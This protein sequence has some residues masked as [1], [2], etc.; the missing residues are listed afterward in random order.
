MRD[1]LKNFAKW[2]DAWSSKND[3]LDS[4]EEEL[5]AGECTVQ[6]LRVLWTNRKEEEAAEEA[7]VIALQA[8]VFQTEVS[9]VTT[10][11][12]VYYTI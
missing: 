10:Y 11:M 2:T 12:N 3:T 8:P 6:C 5:N 1:A 7:A 4:P 9:F